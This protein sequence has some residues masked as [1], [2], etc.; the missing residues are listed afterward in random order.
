MFGEEMEAALFLVGVAQDADEHDGGLQ[1]AGHVHVV[2]ADQTRF[3]HVEFAADGF[4]DFALE[5]FAHTLESEGGHG[6]KDGFMDLWIGG[7]VDCWSNIRFPTIQQSN[8]PIIHQSVVHS[9][10]AVFSI[11]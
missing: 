11:V 10:D 1:I 5:K 3:A 8:H 7:C 9:F 2:D 6:I 4:A